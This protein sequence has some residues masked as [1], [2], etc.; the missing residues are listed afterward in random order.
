LALELRFAPADLITRDPSDPDN[1]WSILEGL[2]PA[3]RTQALRMLR[4]F[5]NAA[6][7]TDG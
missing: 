5:K 4:A 7:G 1:L 2:P 3:E 6:T